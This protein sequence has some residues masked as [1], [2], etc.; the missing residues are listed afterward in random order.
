MQSPFTERNAAVRKRT[1]VGLAFIVLVAAARSSSA[2][3]LPQPQGGIATTGAAQ[4]AQ[5]SSPTLDLGSTDPT[6]VV[7]VSIIFKAQPMGQL[8]AFVQWTQDPSSPTYHRFLSVRDFARSFAPSSKDIARV[9]AYLTTFGI[10]VGATLADNLVL[11]ATGTVGTFTQAFTFQMH[12]FQN[13]WSHYHRAVGAP[14][15]PSTLSDVMLVVTG[16]ST[17]PAF[18]PKVTSAKAAVPNF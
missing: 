10:Q 16:F 14:H 4:S 8:E 13:G 5:S 15:I 1:S 11:K 3:S 12:D 2:T 6:L 7:T 9:S 18:V 17:Q